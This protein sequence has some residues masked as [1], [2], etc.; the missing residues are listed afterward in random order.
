MTT[1]NKSVLLIAET[2]AIEDEWAGI[3]GSYI[4]DPETGNRYPA[5]STSE[6]DES[7]IK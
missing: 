6:R 1:D 4:R 2:P 7:E 3:G 5:P